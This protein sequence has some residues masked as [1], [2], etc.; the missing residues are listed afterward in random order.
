M[1]QD[2]AKQQSN[3]ESQL[4]RR[5]KEKRAAIK[6]A[7]QQQPVVGLVQSVGA[8]SNA[9]ISQSQ[10][11]VGQALLPPST[12]LSSL[13]DADSAAAVA[14][15]SQSSTTTASKS[16]AAPSREAQ[17]SQPDPNNSHQFFDEEDSEDGNTPNDDEFHDAVE[18]I[19][20]SVTLPRQK[21]SALHHRNPSSISKLYLQESDETD[22]DE[23]EQTI[24]VTMHKNKEESSQQQQQQQQ[25]TKTQQALVKS[26]A[27][28]LLASQGKKQQSSNDLSLLKGLVRPVKARRTMVPPRPNYSFNL[29]GTMK[30]CIG[31]DLS[32]I[33]IPVN[34]SEPLSMLQ[35]I[36]E[37]LEYSD[38]LDKAAACDDQWEQM[39]YI[40]AFTISAYST[41]ATRSNKPFN[42]LLGETYECDRLDDYGWRSI[43]EQVS[44]HPPGVAIVSLV[45]SYLYL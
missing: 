5:G 2:M 6:A 7:A 34:F 3:I 33:P 23:D 8:Q 42:P 18:E 19:N 39:A 4:T 21:P 30:N 28:E 27:K 17:S 25:S 38:A 35:R 9:Y 36:T 11:L 32:K 14:A 16:S 22:D 26:N 15:S 44:H 10:K 40:A 31:K 12:L 1:V 45:S 37:E 24:K 13:N 29:W 41:T 43:A 20:F